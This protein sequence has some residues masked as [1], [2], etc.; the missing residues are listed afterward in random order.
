MKI[1]VS[2]FTYLREELLVVCQVHCLIG[3]LL[4]LMSSQ[5]V[6]ND[7]QVSILITNYLFKSL[8]YGGCKQILKTLLSLLEKS[9]SVDVDK[10]DIYMIFKVDSQKKYEIEKSK[11]YIGYKLLWMLR[12]FIEGKTFPSGTNLSL[13]KYRMHIY[14]IA[15]LI[16]VPQCLTQLLQF[17]ASHFLEVLAKLYSTS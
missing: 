5:R 8:N 9:T 7:D 10:D 1:D 17:D 6:N 13:E 11:V 3:A 14:D 4:H 15:N 2:D 12:L 16:T